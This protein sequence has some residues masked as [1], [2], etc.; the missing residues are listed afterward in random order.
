MKEK[1]LMALRGAIQCI[2]TEEDIRKKT[3]LLYRELLSANNLAEQ[4]IVSVIFSVTE[5]LNELNPAT[6]LRAEG[7]ALNTALFV[8]KEAQFK[9]SLE[10]VI[11]LLIHCCLD[12]QKKAVNVYLNG[13]EVLRPD[14]KLY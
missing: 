5:D 6:A 13:A 8:C 4:E 3:V 14:N 9:G 11:R 10:R 1:T 2:N 7:F 12:A